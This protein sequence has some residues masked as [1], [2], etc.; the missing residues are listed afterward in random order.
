MDASSRDVRGMAAAVL[1][2][3]VNKSGS[4]GRR[5]LVGGSEQ[6]GHYTCFVLG[7]LG[8]N[9]CVVWPEFAEGIVKISVLP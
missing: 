1:R 9:P 2:W 3:K 7:L 8:P 5:S 4:M 6:C